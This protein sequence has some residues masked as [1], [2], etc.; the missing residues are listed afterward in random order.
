MATIKLCLLPWLSAKGQTNMD[1]RVCG[2]GRPDDDWGRKMYN[3]H[4]E[5]YKTDMWRAHMT[6]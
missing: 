2:R 1:T 3:L 5:Q 4:L 6:P